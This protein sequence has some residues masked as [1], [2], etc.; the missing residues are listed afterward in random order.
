MYHVSFQGVHERMISLHIIIIIVIIN[1]IIIVSSCTYAPIAS[2]ILW[3]YDKNS[4]KLTF[5]N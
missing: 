2:G 1:I 5:L 3:V 4:K